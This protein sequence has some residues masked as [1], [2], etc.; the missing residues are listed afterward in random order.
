[1]SSSWQAG[2]YTVGGIYVAATLLVELKAPVVGIGRP[3]FV[4]IVDIR[5]FGVE[6]LAEQT[7]LVC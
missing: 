6:H 4:K 5:T 1:M 3:E 7:L 2:A